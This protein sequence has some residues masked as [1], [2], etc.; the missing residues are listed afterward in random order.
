MSTFKEI[1]RRDA[2]KFGLAGGAC[3]LTGGLELFA[4]E[5]ASKADVWVIHGAD[6]AKLMQKAL[7]VIQ[8]NGGFGHAVNKLALKVNA[9][10][11]RTPAQGATTHPELVEHFL[12]GCREFGV[13]NVS[14]PEFSCDSAKE[15]FVKSGIYEAVSKA[16]YKM[17][18]ITGGSKNFAPVDVPK[19]KSL[20]DVQVVDDF[21]HADAIVNMPVCKSHG[22]AGLSLAMKNW[23][24]SIKDRGWWHNNNLPQCVADFNTIVRPTWTII[25]ATRVM[26][27]RGPRG[28][29][30]DTRTPDLLIISKDQVAADAYAAIEFWGSSDKAKYIGI[31]A[32]MGLGVA[33]LD[34]MNVR[35]LEA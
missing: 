13:G 6:K 21:L 24:G 30:D 34:L 23:M 12:K 32:E 33:S 19:G 10:W 1:T 3:L 18:E 7:Q 16:G 2:I 28:P 31:A 25:D 17:T 4:E 22:G 27:T 14:V 29:S 26:M 9:A 20:K 35:K 15:S 11:A 5:A 8:E